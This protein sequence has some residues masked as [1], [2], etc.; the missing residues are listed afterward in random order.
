MLKITIAV[1]VLAVCLA[2]AVSLGAVERSESFSP[3]VDG[4]GNIMLPADF[5]ST[6][7]HLGTWVVTSRL[8]AGLGLSNTAPTPGLHEVYTQTESFKSYKKDGKWPEGTVLVMEIRTIQW[9]DVSTGHVIYAGDISRWF[10]MIKD[11]K[12][13]FP[14]NPN[15]GEGWGWGLFNASDPKKN[16]S[17]DFKTDCIDCHEPVK[18]T[19]WIHIQGYP[20]LK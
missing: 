6:W 18:K 4:K 3:Y 13:R 8:A 7:S 16:I 17:T 20:S 1:L 11:T 2:A 19:D 15:W 5:R 10:V 12:G 14:G 9:D